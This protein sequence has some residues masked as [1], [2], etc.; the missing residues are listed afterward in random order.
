MTKCQ[1]QL[2]QNTL[3]LRSAYKWEEQAPRCENCFYYRNIG[4]CFHPVT[5][6]Y[7][8]SWMEA[9]GASTLPDAYCTG[10]V[11]HPEGGWE[12]RKGAEP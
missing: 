3:V 2:I 12:A 9:V 1:E 10:Y 4:G 7:N 11:R 5:L 6:R 8:P